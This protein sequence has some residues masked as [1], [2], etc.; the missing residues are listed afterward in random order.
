MSSLHS[1]RAATTLQRETIVDFYP[2]KSEFR[3][4]KG[5]SG[6]SRPKRASRAHFGVSSGFGRTR[7]ATT[8]ALDSFSRSASYVDLAR[9]PCYE[10]RERHCSP[11]KIAVCLGF[12]V[13]DVSCNSILMSL[14]CKNDLSYSFAAAGVFAG[15]LAPLSV[16]VDGLL[17]KDGQR[18]EKLT[19]YIGDN[20]RRAYVARPTSCTAGHPAPVVVLLHQFYGLRPRACT[21]SHVEVSM[22]MTVIISALKFRRR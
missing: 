11:C 9:R 18:V 12:I 21:S 2:V 17:D 19:N 22:Y 7:T 10:M 16:L 15:A 14:V 3:S 4:L 6:P 5:T 20:D 13:K 8:C 1:R